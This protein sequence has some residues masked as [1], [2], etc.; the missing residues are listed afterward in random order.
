MIEKETSG[1]DRRKTIRNA[2]VIAVI[3]GIYFFLT[4]GPLRLDK[5]RLGQVQTGRP[6]PDFVLPGLDGREVRLS[7]YRGKVVFLNIW[8][9]WCSP[10]RQEMPSMQK[11]YE[12]LKGY[13][14][15]MLAV[16]IDAQGADVVR[17]FVNR[18]KLTFP[19]L[20][21][22]AGNIGRLYNTTGV[23]E[24]FIIDRS[25]ILVSKTIGAHNWA[26][27]EAVDFIKKLSR[28]TP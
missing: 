15:E 28:K 6:A 12:Q 5:P 2:I 8:A 10:C 25:G 26:D 11:L 1:T 24:T 4:N 27:P 16:S 19:V 7:D 3:F 18:S 22:T 9:S 13:D 23:P 20:L 21:D 14:F 17:P